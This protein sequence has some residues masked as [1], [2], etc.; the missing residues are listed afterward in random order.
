MGLLTPSRSL[1]RHSIESFISSAWGSDDPTVNITRSTPSSEAARLDPTIAQLVERQPAPA[2]PRAKGSASAAR[3]EGSSSS[4]RRTPELSHSRTPSLSSSRISPDPDDPDDAPFAKLEKK[5]WK[6]S[7]PFKR[8]KPPAVDLHHSNASTGTG[9]LDNGLPSPTSVRSTAHSTVQARPGPGSGISSAWRQPHSSANSN[10]T[11]LS[12]ADSSDSHTTHATRA[13]VQFASINARSGH[14][15]ESAQVLPS[16]AGVLAPMMGRS[17]ISLN[18][19]A[20]WRQYDGA[21][22][23]EED[24]PRPDKLVSSRK[25]QHPHAPGQFPSSASAFG[26]STHAQ[27]HQPPEPPSAKPS[28]RKLAKDRGSDAELLT[29]PAAHAQGSRPGSVVEMGD[30]M[31]VVPSPRQAQQGTP[32]QPNR[33]RSVSAHVPPPPSPTPSARAPSSK[34]SLFRRASTTKPSRPPVT[35]RTQA[36]VKA[37]RPMS[38]SKLFSRSSSNLPEPAA[39]PPAPKPTGLLVPAEIRAKEDRVKRSIQL[40]WLGNTLTQEQIAYIKSS[41]SSNRDFNGILAELEREQSSA[42]RTS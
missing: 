27:Q 39:Q 37:K 4:T 25:K 33:P 13:S 23:G 8:G 3:R 24:D 15:R 5:K 38:L 18:D 12:A 7:N 30:W 34:G 31:G 6:L 40:L 19:S 42:R 1:R 28:S 21:T 14:H 32:V 36:A 22:E 29:T 26:L 16:E 41:L 10:S 2:D 17:R 35:A 20:G 9:L 11:Q